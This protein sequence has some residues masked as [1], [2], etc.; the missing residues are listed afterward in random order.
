MPREESAYP[1]DWLRIA[2]KD[3][4]RVEHL[5]TV[6]DSEAAGFYLQQAVE[7]F[8]KAFLLS[9]GWQLQR[10][11]DL[12]ILLNAALAYDP[13]FESYRSACQKITGFYTIERYPF[14]TETG[15]TQDDVRNSLK[16]VE[17]LIRK[18]RVEV[19]GNVA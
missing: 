2:E 17:E 3:L 5:L 8:L 12:E 19:G 11:H 1:A 18:V 7:K 16:H 6:Q 13:S 10:I 15:L 4:K 14:V 9:K